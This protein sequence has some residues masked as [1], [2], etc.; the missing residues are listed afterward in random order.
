[1]MRGKGFVLSVAG[2]IA[3]AVCC[4]AEERTERFDKDPGWD[5]HNNRATTPEKRTVRQDFGF[6][7][8]ANAGGKVGEIGGFIS[9]AAEPAYYARKIDA[10]TFGDSLSASG[11]LLCKGPSCHLL[12]GFFNADTVNEWRT[13]N[14]VSLRLLGRGD[15][16]Y[17]YVEYC[18]SKWRAGGDSP[19]GFAT[20]KN[21]KTDR[22][23]LRGFKTGV[24]HKWSI[25]YDPAGNK[26]GGSVT[27][28]LG[29][30]TAVCHLDAGHKS[31][32][33]T[34]NRFGLLPVLKS[35][36]GGGEVWLDDVTVNGAAD[37]FAKDPGW[38]GVGNR[39]EY[40]TADVRPR[41]DFGYSQTKHAG[42]K[43][44][45]ELGGLVFRGDCRYKTKLAA[46]GDRL[47][48]LSL[49]TPL[50]ASGKVAMRRGVSDST[51]LLGFYHSEDSLTVN[52]SQSS[53]FPKSFLGVALEGPSR[54]G[55]LFYPLY[56][57]RGDG[58]GYANGADRPHIMPDGKSHDWSLDYDPTAANGQGRMVVKFGGKSVSLDLGAGDR[59]TGARFDRFGLVTTWIDGNA[60]RVYFDDL[61]YTCGP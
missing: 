2:I 54:D 60:Q 11:T 49:D 43:G 45:G 42:G 23:E 16:F 8:T 50:K 13:P 5:G 41:F 25:T 12:V 15:V 19:G 47:K 4:A 31:D 59:K 37:D 1:M 26:G 6:S 48:P 56:R 44:A 18:T 33:A 32:G 39:R 57:V 17:A 38:E 55:F 58:Q 34:F 46:Y 9:P 24:A 35:A 36:D 30:E 21:A 3:I 28:T 61:T 29:G 10:K 53:G 22:I 20:V 7:K 14:T 40:Q 27:V 51:V 52:P